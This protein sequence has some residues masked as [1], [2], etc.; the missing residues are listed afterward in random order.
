MS[1]GRAKIDAPA[2]FTDRDEWLKACRAKRLRGPFSLPMPQLEQ[3]VCDMGTAAIW[4]GV[5][6]K[7][8][9]FNDKGMGQ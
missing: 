1:E 7:G 9:V 4:N 6:N 2:A 5:V 3:F 8:V